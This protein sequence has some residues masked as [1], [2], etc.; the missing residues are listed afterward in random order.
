MTDVLIIGGGIMGLAAARE[1]LLA[2]ARVCLLE[3][4]AVGQE[5]SW[6]GGGILSPLYP[7]R[8]PEPIARL[9]LW[10]HAEYP[11]L[12]AAIRERTG[13]D[14]EWTRSGLL[15]AD[16]EN[17]E[18]AA[19]WCATHALAAEWPGEDEFRALEPGLA[20]RPRSPV[21]L[22]DIAQVRNPRL[23]AAMRT[24]VLGLGGQILENRAVTGMAVAG[25]GV[26][27]VATEQ[28]RHRA[29]IYVIA[30]GAWSGLLGRRWAPLP[31]LKVEPVKGQ[32]IIF[33]APPGTLRHIVLAEGRYLIPR[34]DGRILAGSTVEY[35]EFDKSTSDAARRELEAFARNLLPDLDIAVE[36][37]WAGL[38]PGSPS[39]IPYIGPHPE[40]DNLFFDCGHFRNGFVMAPASA[41]LLADLVLGRAPA[42]EPE[43]YGLSAEH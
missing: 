1:L 26:D 12:A 27:Y 6:A 5:S 8:V 39:G 11:Q 9:F 17:R 20:V 7:W 40:I 33:K 43:A 32:M 14:P 30:A 16:C 10:S 42:I 15:I 3:R 22:P 37:H 35:S 19:S 25:R 4:Q 31:A 38:R 28:Q 2:G 24:E 34:R 18:L 23:I 13:I 41:R 29:G 36:K 21:H